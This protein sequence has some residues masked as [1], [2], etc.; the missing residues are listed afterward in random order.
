MKKIVFKKVCKVSVIAIILLLFI[1][2]SVNAFL[3][4]LNPINYHY[5]NFLDIQDFDALNSY[6]LEGELSD[7][8]IKTLTPEAS[9]VH[10]VKY[11]GKTF[12]I[13]AYIFSNLEET[14]CYY[15]NCTGD[16]PP[17]ES[18]HRVS[19][20][21]FH[22]SFITYQN[23]CVYRV[24]GGNSKSVIEFVEYISS[25]FDSPLETGSH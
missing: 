14:I 20:T 9:Y 17:F 5:R 16:S 10:Y 21:I 6:I 19:S 1:W 12:Q 23:C 8:K 18:F 4:F 22:T 25:L 7:S 24:E 2:L 13:F 11:N 3:S 15:D